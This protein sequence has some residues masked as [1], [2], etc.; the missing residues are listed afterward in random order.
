MSN[1]QYTDFDNI[2]YLEVLGAVE[3]EEEVALIRILF[4]AL[5]LFLHF[6]ISF[7]QPE[8]DEWSLVVF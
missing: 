7:G 3:L 1:Y 6:L 2:Y 5:I 4:K 8:L